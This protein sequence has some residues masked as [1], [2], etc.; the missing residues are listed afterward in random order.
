M[1]GR[2]VIVAPVPITAAAAPPTFQPLAHTLQFT[3]VARMAVGITG[4]P[5]GIAFGAVGFSRLLS[6]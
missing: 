5:S 2:R 1:K 6:V 3:A 4:A